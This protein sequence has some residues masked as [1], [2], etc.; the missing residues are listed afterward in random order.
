MRPS[1]WIIAIAVAIGTGLGT[2]AAQS[3]A[4]LAT[5]R[6]ALEKL[7]AAGVFDAQDCAAR[8]T[9]LGGPAASPA[10]PPAIPPVAQSA[11]PPASASAPPSLAPPSLVAPAL[12]APALAPPS[13][14][15]GAA[16]QAAARVFRD[17]GGR[18]AA[19]VPEGW[20]VSSENGTARITSGADWV[21]LIP[22]AESAPDAAAS[23]IVNQ[24]RAQYR[25]LTEAGS[26]R[27]RIGGHDV[28]Y[29]TFRGVT[30]AG[31]EVAVMAAGIQAPGNHVLV[32][33]SS[34]PLAEI[35]AASPNFLSILNGIRFAGE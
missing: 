25:S 16:P 8:R 6:A 24:I 4:T 11:P 9:A 15:A 30:G 13:A 3:D 2:A 29:A 31:A 20:N 34:A 28:A 14:T 19:P 5:K 23:Q 35:N 1:R 32:F 21:M 33:L 12:A 22:A 26:G 18:Y 7:C 27:P 17:P 10:I